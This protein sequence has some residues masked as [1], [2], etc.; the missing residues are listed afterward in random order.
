MR[1]LMQDTLEAKLSR[2]ILQNELTKGQ[3]F[4]AGI[5]LLVE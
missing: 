3:T 2:L 4:K 1:R 5:E